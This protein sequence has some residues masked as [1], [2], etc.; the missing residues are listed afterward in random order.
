[1][2]KTIKPITPQPSASEV[3]VSYREVV[4]FRNAA[5][6]Y[7]QEHPKERTHLSFV[8]EKLIKKYAPFVEDWSAIQRELRIKHASKDPR[9]KNIIET[10]YGEGENAVIRYSYTEENQLAMDKEINERYNGT[11]DGQYKIVVPKNN[12]PI[13][14]EQIDSLWLDAFTPFVFEPMEDDVKLQWY[15]NSA[16]K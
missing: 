1:M 2:A 13:Q 7:L 16:K 15:L 11:E 10:Q 3:L 4:T 8:L 12:I 5:A 9:T 6:L 14:L